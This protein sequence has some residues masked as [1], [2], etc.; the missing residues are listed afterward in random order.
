MFIT[1]NRCLVDV[2]WFRQ[3]KK[4]TGF[5][6]GDQDSAG[7]ASGHPGPIDNT[8]LLKGITYQLYA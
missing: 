2:K 4:Y 5:D 3:W 6:S 7:Q 8:N 1:I